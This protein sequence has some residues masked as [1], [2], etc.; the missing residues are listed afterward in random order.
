VAAGSSLKLS[1]RV[2]GGPAN[3]AAALTHGKKTLAKATKRAVSGKVT[4]KLR[5]GRRAKLGPAT[6]TLR[7][8]GAKP[9]VEKVT[10]TKHR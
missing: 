5:L 9:L 8:T 3:L 10:V 4:L 6:L 7:L 2:G 1:L